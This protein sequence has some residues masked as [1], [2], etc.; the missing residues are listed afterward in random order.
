MARTS[1]SL[2]R[3][4]MPLRVTSKMSSSPEV[5]TT[6]T[7]S[8]PSRRLMAMNPSRRDLSYSLKAV[9]LTWPCAVAKTRYWSG[10]NSRVVMMAWI[11]SFGA[12]GTRFT[13]AVPLAVRSFMGI[14]WPRRR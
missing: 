14:S 13:A 10:E 11:D 4:V 3:M 8:S 2:K 5:A 12:S 7:S 6:R 1:V 9:F